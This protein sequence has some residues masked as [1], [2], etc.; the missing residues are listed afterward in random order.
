[1]SVETG[2]YGLAI[3]GILLVLRLPVALALILVSFGGIWSMV[4]WNPTF[5][6]LQSTP[7]T[8][9]AKWTM[10]AVPCSC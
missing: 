5:Y 10:S 9:V 3:L 6:A 8:F 2:L 7:Y 4:G 1:M